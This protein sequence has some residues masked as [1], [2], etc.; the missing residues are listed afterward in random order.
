MHDRLLMTF[1]LALGLLVSGLFAST[2]ALADPVHDCTNGCTV[3]TCDGE[4]CTI[5]RCD[6]NACTYAGSFV[7][8]R[9]PK[10]A[11]DQLAGGGDEGQRPAD[12]ACNG[13]R[14]C[15]VRTCQANTCSIW[16]LAGGD[17][18]LL[19][20]LENQQPLIDTWISEF[21]AENRE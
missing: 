21:L 3:I 6:R 20:T 7:K 9:A 12:L 19:G 16:G 18:R 14:A 1:M 11:G 8:E 4:V 2:A 15:V 17:K 10:G 5:W 13:E